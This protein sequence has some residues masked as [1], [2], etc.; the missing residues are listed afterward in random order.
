MSPIWCFSNQLTGKRNGCAATL[1][2]ATRNTQRDADL[3]FQKAD[4]MI[5]AL[6]RKARFS[7]SAAETRVGEDGKMNAK[8]GRA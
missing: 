5:A 8:S 3:T 4:L 1:N 6:K 7:Y 2:P